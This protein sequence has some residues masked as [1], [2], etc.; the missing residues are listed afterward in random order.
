MI[1][2]LKNESSFTSLLAKG[3]FILD[4]GFRDCISDNENAF[5]SG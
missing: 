4:R 2:I 1:D 3:D 5:S